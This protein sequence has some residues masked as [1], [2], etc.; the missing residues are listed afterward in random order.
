MCHVYRLSMRPARCSSSVP[1]PRHTGV[2]WHIVAPSGYTESSPQNS[3]TSAAR[4]AK[5]TRVN[6]STKILHC[7]AQAL[8]N[9]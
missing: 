6:F 8:A 4:E 7:L 3:P 5:E 1:A 9:I 2:G